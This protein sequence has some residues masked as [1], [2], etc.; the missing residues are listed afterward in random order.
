MKALLFLFFALMCMLF[1]CQP[2]PKS[3][4]D[5]ED[6]T[7]VEYVDTTP[8]ATAIFWIDKDKPGQRPQG[9][10]SVRTAKAK[11]KIYLTGRIE[12]LSYVKPQKNHIKNYINRRLETF[13]VR[14]A[15]MDS[16][17]INPGI[18]YVQ[19]RYTPSK[20]GG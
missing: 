4:S 18:Q 5:G 9:G 17:Y 7:Q 12:V 3:Q 1:S 20:V 11:V 13:R 16:A 19:L 10:I 8:K 6:E 14:K 15:L 2:S